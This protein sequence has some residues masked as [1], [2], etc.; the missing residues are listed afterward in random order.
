MD[1]NLDA[2][3]IRAIAMLANKGYLRKKER[4]EAA[5]QLLEDG[6]SISDIRELAPNLLKPVP[7][8]SA[9]TGSVS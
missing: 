2:E 8:R 5:K 6:L 3:E 7:P 1:G 9:E 4:N